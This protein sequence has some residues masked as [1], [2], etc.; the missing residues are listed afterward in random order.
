MSDVLVLDSGADTIKIGMGLLRQIQGIKR[1]LHMIKN[2]TEKST[3]TS[4]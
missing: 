1:K 4:A 3:D 2:G